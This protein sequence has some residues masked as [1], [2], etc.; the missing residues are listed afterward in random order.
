VEEFINKLWTRLQKGI[1]LIKRPFS[2]IADE[3]HS[4]EEDLIIVINNLIKKGIIREIAPI[5]EADRMNYGS[6]L[7]AS[8]VDENELEGFAGFVNK[9]PGVTHNYQREGKM[10]VWFTLTIPMDVSI[11]KTL[12]VFKK[13]KGVKSLFS[14][15]KEK[16]YK[17]RV[18]FNLSGDKSESEEIKASRFEEHNI[19]ED[20]L[21]RSVRLLQES[22]TIKPN[23]FSLIAEEMGVSEDDFIELLN[24]MYDSGVIRRFPAM[25]K[26]KKVG[27]THNA[28]IAWKV[29]D[30]KIDEL[31][32][33]F[34]KFDYITHC[35]KR[36][37]YKGWPYNLYTMAHARSEDELRENLQQMENIDKSVDHIV[38][39]SI[40]EYKKIRVKYFDSALGEWNSKHLK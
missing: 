27:F 28:L 23:P 20:V 24:K 38:L 3:L 33:K 25:L 31:G 37:T 16:T 8:E 36:K 26:H 40:K 18:A 14:L 4:T 5:F 2:K 10:N 29:N 11:E 19:P 32:F 39:K 35:Y 15:P 6:T 22:F 9:H 13:E 17:I 30:E 7:V 1:P 12:E 34:A 21:K